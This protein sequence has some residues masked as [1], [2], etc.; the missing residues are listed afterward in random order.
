M[1]VDLSE[2]SEYPL[3]DEI[4]GKQVA[5]LYYRLSKVRGSFL[6]IEYKMVDNNDNLM[7]ISYSDEMLPLGLARLIMSETHYDYSKP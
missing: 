5:I 3:I 1:P 2:Y 4:S 6:R 7:H